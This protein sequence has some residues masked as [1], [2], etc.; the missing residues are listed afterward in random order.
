MGYKAYTLMHVGSKSQSK[1]G[2]DFYRQFST[3]PGLGGSKEKVV[4]LGSGWGGL[5]AAEES[6]RN[7]SS[8]SF[9]SPPEQ[10]SLLVA[11]GVG[12]VVRVTSATAA[13]TAAAALDAAATADVLSD[14]EGS[15]LLAIDGSGR[16]PLR[17][18]FE[19]VFSTGSERVVEI[20]LESVA[21]V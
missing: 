15:L 1:F 11:V 20:W 14:D 6:G 13:E 21:G 2:V 8:S 7:T 5:T 12:G 16:R 18:M 4:I 19:S 9:W 17:S 3:T 10:L